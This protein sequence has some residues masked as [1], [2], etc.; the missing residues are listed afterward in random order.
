MQM[1]LREM[2]GY[3][4][5]GDVTENGGFLA[6]ARHADAAR[7]CGGIDGVRS[8]CELVARAVNAADERS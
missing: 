6:A 3:D 7:C 4:A 5:H 8:D 1:C 2:G